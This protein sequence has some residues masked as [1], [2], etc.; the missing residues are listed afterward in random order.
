MRVRNEL[1]EWLRVEIAIGDEPIALENERDR[2]ADRMIGIEFCRDGGR[3]VKGVIVFVE[4]IRRFDLFHFLARG[5]VDSKTRFDELFFRDRG[6]E[7][8]DPNR[9]L[10][11]EG[12]FTDLDPRESMR[13]RYEDVQHERRMACQMA[14]RMTRARSGFT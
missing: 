4:S 3:H 6:L 10:R 8:V 1:I 13:L 5:Y 9:W 12:G 7:E 14:C 11:N 2:G